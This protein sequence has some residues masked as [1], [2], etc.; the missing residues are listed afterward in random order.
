MFISLAVPSD[1]IQIMINTS[2][3]T[4]AGSEFIMT[5]I[6]VKAISGLTHMPTATWNYVIEDN[7]RPVVTGDGVTMTASRSDSLVIAI[8][9]FN[10][11][12]ISHNG[13]YECNGYLTSPA[14]SESSPIGV[15]SY[16]H[17]TVQGKC[18]IINILRCL[19]NECI[20]TSYY[21]L[22]Q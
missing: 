15:I 21:T 13:V 20:P 7:S 19:S 12:K 1:P 14:Y 17:L 5:C 11:L 4:V 10:P 16:Q 8:L 2:G 9:T 18:C 3:S 22:R 6:I